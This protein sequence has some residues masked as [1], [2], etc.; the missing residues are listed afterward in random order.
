LKNVCE[1]N[2]SYYNSTWLSI[3][4]SSSNLVFFKPSTNWIDLEDEFQFLIG[5]LQVVYMY[6]FN[7]NEFHVSLY[8]W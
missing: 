4:S 8:D 7:T 3:V 5:F 2:Q 6:M 1:L